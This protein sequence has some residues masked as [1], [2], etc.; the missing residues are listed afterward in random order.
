MSEVYI[1]STWR[2][3]VAHYIDQGLKIVFYLPFMK[4]FFLILFT[5]QAVSLSVGQWIIL[6][7]ITPFYEAVFLALMQATP[8]KWM[9]GL[10][11]VPAR[12]PEEPLQWQQC[13]LRPA[14]QLLTFFFSWALYALAFFRYDRT[15]LADWVAETR[16]VQSTR[17]PTRAR[18]RPFLGVIL[19]L[20][21]TYGG[22]T[23]AHKMLRAVK[24]DSN[25]VD[26]REFL[27]VDDYENLFDEYEYE[28]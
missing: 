18:L 22:L 24:W 2:R 5:D 16:V 19:I 25:T 1:P 6:L 3:W 26:L 27:G 7:L 15:H 20:F 9:M 8:G 13:V 23:S 4:S 10:K 28:D 17:R 21:N 14:V 12:S 11:V